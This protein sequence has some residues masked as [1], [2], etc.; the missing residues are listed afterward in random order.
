MTAVALCCTGSAFSATPVCPDRYI[1]MVIP[2]P[3]G[4]VGDM[5]GRLLGDKASAI[6]GQTMVFENIPGATTMIGTAAAARAKPDGCT[7]LH[8]TT[9]G[10]VASVMRDNLPFSLERDF[11]AVVGV[12]S[13]PLALSVNAKSKIKTFGDLVAAT[14]AGDG[15][16]YS[17]GGS[18]TMAHLAALRMLKEI[19]GKGTHVP[20]KGNAPAIQ[21]LLA[22][23]VDFMFP[24]SS[25]ALALMQGDKLR[26]LALT[27][28][29]PLATFP[30]VPTMKDL[31]F[32]DFAPRIWYAFL[33]PAGTPA[34]AVAR[35]QDAFA[36]ALADP[37][38]QERLSARG[39]I[40]EVRGSADVSA[41][42][43]AEA[44]RWKMVVKEN[45]ITSED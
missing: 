12:G 32:A 34:D 22:G 24:S 26:V 3:A 13:F 45:N 36:K 28:E 10:V 37:T 44:A 8:L 6:L 40:S 2:Q 23:D 39:Y 25:E 38:V 1:R 21:G 16:N 33:V 31:G 29:K 35:M 27:S 18:G 30:N 42:I 41:F 43:K 20:Y 11:T 14:K 17:T 19:G 4:G 15:L 9:S 7:I 5:I